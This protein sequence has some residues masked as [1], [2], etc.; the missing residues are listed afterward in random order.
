LVVERSAD[1]KLKRALE[2]ANK[3]GARFSIIFGD[4]ELAAG[5]FQLKNMVSGEQRSLA[6]DQ[7]APAIARSQSADQR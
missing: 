7:L 1:K 5:T 3:M 2:I 6:R 4:D